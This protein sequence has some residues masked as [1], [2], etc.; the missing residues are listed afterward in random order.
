MGALNR[1]ERTF[2]RKA[3]VIRER[4]NQTGM[5]KELKQGKMKRTV[6]GRDNLNITLGPVRTNYVR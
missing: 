2:E 1:R 5:K 6:K 3:R 4:V